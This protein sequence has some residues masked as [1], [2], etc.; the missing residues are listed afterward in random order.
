MA[1][2]PIPTLARALKVRRMQLDHT[3]E[4]A[5]LALDVHKQTISF[6]ET[7]GLPLTK[8]IPAL[9]KYLACDGDLLIEMIERAA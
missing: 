4:A 5:G 3:Q 1:D 2:E 6:W 7:G 9:H 8:Q